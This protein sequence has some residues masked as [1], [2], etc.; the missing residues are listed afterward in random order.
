[1][2]VSD[3]LE[4]NER[5]ILT[6]I[7]APVAGMPLRLGVPGAGDVQQETAVAQGQGTQP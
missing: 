3:G 2:F 1:V 5:L 6:D 7:A 4:E